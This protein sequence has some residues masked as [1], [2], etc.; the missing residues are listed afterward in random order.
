MWSMKISSWV[1][2]RADAGTLTQVGFIS[3]KSSVHIVPFPCKTLMLMFNSVVEVIKLSF[4]L[5]TVGY[6]MLFS[7]H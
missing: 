5:V 2:A 7:N 1:S 6:N 3:C 4:V